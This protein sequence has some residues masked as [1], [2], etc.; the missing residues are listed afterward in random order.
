M[1]ENARE[2]AR[3]EIA[4]CESLLAKGGLSVLTDTFRNTTEIRAWDHYPPGDVFDP[5]S[6]SQWF[7]HCH[8]AEEGAEEHGHFHC[9]LRP[10]GPEGPIHHLAAVGVDAR[11]RLLRLFTVNQWVVGDDW[12]DAE[13]TIALLPRFDVQMPRPSYLVNRW[14]T[15]VFAAWDEEIAGLIRERDRALATHR[16]AEGVEARQDRVLEVISELKLAAG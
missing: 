13:G 11:G 8:P 5:A 7:Y 3:R 16:P 6:G 9:F 10:R 12:L 2:L 4:F 14:L 1:A 15:A